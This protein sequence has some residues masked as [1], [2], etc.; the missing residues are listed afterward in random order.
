MTNSL[1][2]FGVKGMKWGKNK[3]KDKKSS[4]SAKQHKMGDIVSTG[5]DGSETIYV[6]AAGT[7]G[8]FLSDEEQKEIDSLV[9]ELDALYNEEIEL[10]NK[11]YDRG[12][13][14]T[15]DPKAAELERIKTQKY[16]RY[17][18][19]YA[20][21]QKAQKESYA[22]GR[23]NDPMPH[24]RGELMPEPGGK[25][26]TRSKSIVA[27][28]DD[29]KFKTKDRKNTVQHTDIDSYLEHHGVKGMKWGV[30]K[31]RRSGSS[32][33]S[34]SKAKTSKTKSVPKGKA[35]AAK[36]PSNKSNFITDFL[37]ADKRASRKID[38]LKSKTKSE[39]AETARNNKVSKA[40]EELAK[41]K[42]ANDTSK[43]SEPKMSRRDK[44][45]A[46]LDAKLDRKIA[47]QKYKQKVSAANYSDKD[48]KQ[49]I[50]RMEMEKKYASLM[51]ERRPKSKAENF[52]K[53]AKTTATNAL[54]N[55]GQ[56]IV[57][58]AVGASVS[59]AMAKAI[60]DATAGD[61]TTQI[62]SKVFGGSKKKGGDQ[63]SDYS[64]G[65]SAATKQYPS[66][67]S[68]QSKPKSS[69]PNTLAPRPKVT[70]PRP[71]PTPSERRERIQ[72]MLDSSTKY[73]DSQR[74]GKS[75]PNSMTFSGKQA[76][77]GRSPAGQ[78]AVSIISKYGDS[79]PKTYTFGKSESVS[80]SLKRLDTNIGWS[81]TLNRPYAGPGT[82]LAS[83]QGFDGFSG[84]KRKRR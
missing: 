19:L 21:A 32:S 11:V 71:S 72:N 40:K 68:P 47:K 73:L 29:V 64:G 46:K 35:A 55:E 54:K 20:K 51:E 75:S 34:S 80:D 70:T 38:R 18:E 24:L 49:K 43:S 10:Q 7:A 67:N 45:Q 14:Y 76:S 8:R 52:K 31:D 65:P 17:N 2:H 16:D 62:L 59:Y 78:R 77:T 26:Y 82:S 5:S 83:R 57:N 12:G 69:G 36:K 50:N 1:E 74:S 25:T 37:D 58:A 23:K 84:N 66:Y 4:N 41:A 28:P 63:K 56:K 79:K 44:K 48:L 9:D 53:F 13:D 60:G 15:K 22:N 6:G 61:A 3:A 33:S 42:A 39:K 27:G 81:K 30:R